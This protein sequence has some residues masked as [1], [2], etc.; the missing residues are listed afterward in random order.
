MQLSNEQSLTE[1]R[2]SVSPGNTNHTDTHALLHTEQVAIFS[3]NGSVKV[4]GKADPALSGL[5]HNFFSVCLSVL[6]RSY[7]NCLADNAGAWFTT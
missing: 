6:P 5:H 7:M 1:I 4:K 3:H 2:K